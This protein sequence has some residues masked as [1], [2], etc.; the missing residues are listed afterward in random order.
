MTEANFAKHAASFDA[1]AELY[2]KARPSYPVPAVD[3]VLP[4]N[5]AEVLDLGA[6]T[7]KFTRLFADRVAR[8]VAVDP[9]E[10]MLEQLSLTVPTAETIVASAESI[11]LPDESVDAVVCA[12]AWHWVDAT[13]AASE[14]AR[15]L[16]PGG[17][18]GLLWNSR[19]HRVDWVAR[20][21][22][23]IN[24][25]SPDD[26]LEHP[27]E[28]PGPF[29]AME[30]LELDWQHD[31]TRAELRALVASRSHFIVQTRPEQQRV[32]DALDAMLDA[33]PQT[34]GL[35]QIPV[36]YRTLCFRS[37]LGSSAA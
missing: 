8:V 29:T 12:Q 19:D 15:V 3:W 24:E 21:A 22:E 20:M 4:G 14:L 26:I 31:L 13:A 1:A 5:P 11:P 2:E 17:T 37:T 28:L 36:P 23:I 33:H 32:L 18:V 27:P 34:A 9:S 25:A 10:R 35:E 7:G 16:R 30:F 6:G